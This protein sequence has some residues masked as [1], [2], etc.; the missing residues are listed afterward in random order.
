MPLTRTGWLTV[1]VLG[2]GAG[3][4]LALFLVADQPPLQEAAT[5]QPPAVQQFTGRS[6]THPGGEAAAGGEHGGGEGQSS[7][8]ESQQ[9][10][11]TLLA[12]LPV[13]ADSHDWAGLIQTAEDLVQQDGRYQ[14][15][16]SPY[17]EQAYS[18]LVRSALDQG[19]S[20]EAQRWLAEAERSL[21]ES[22]RRLLLQA[23]LDQLAG[24]FQAARAALHR[25]IALDPLAAGRIYPQIRL[26]VE[27]LT[28]G[29]GG[30]LTLDEKIALL[31]EELVNDPGHAVYYALLGRLYYQQGH[32]ELAVA[33][34]EYAM[35]LDAALVPE[36]S[37]LIDVVQQR[38]DSPGLLEVPVISRGH[39]L[40]VDA[41]LNAS[42]RRYR[43]VLDTGASL[44][45]I[46]AG[47]ARALG[48]AITADLPRV[49]LATAN[50]MLR[51]PV[52]SL[53]SVRVGGAFV[54][55]VQAVVLPELEGADGL[56]GLSF[57]NR[58]DMDIN[59]SEGKLLLR[60]RP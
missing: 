46:S 48:V 31:S 34:L 10:I 21:G 51:A 52:I 18:A 24:R 59:H 27:S 15:Q 3:Y 6:R 9:K 23:E 60:R 22:E 25:T 17:L 58:F 35:Q 40:Y 2:L 42:S 33:N 12:R 7:V 13:L 49:E 54:E 4:S 1:F 37:S 53:R 32:N 57:L 30:P 47:T 19:A 56:L 39:T 5:G 50:G 36:L 45:A 11:A 44:T 55:H 14:S 41:M 20:V 38:Q 16:L 8:A 29:R 28:E 43:L 26:L